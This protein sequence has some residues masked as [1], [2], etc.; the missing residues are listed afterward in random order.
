MTTRMTEPIRAAF[1]AAG[2]QAGIVSDE[3]SVEYDACGSGQSDGTELDLSPA[4]Q[5]RDLEAVIDAV[6]SGPVVLVASVHSGPAAIAY[7]VRHPKRLSALILWGTYSSGAIFF[8]DDRVRSVRG[9]LEQDWN[10][11][12]ETL[13]V[14]LLGWEHPAVVPVLAALLASNTSA[15]DASR[16]LQILAAD[17]STSLLPEVNVPTLVLGRLG[18]FLTPDIPRTVAK[19]IPGARLAY[20]H[21]SAFSP[22]LGESSEVREAIDRFLKEVP[23]AQP[24]AR[25]A[26]TPSEP[27]R[28]VA[29][30]PVSGE[31]SER[32]LEVLG[33]VSAGLTNQQLADELTVSLATV[34]K[35][36]HNAN[37]KLGVRNRLQAVSRAR[38]LGLLRE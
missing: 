3:L 4:A 31:L 12:T 15:A 5:L 26:A 34:K 27:P 13:A 9:L 24:D 16:E 14:Q 17:D 2:T 36:L 29:A 20:A 23:D 8:S 19:G 30:S 7:A 25:P 21:G 10:L 1:E 33:H 6:S 32:E 38:D 35:H 28:S 22:L 18:P 37:V 11:F